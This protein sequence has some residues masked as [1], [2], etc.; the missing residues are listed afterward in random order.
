MSVGVHAKV[1]RAVIG[2]N[3]KE[4]SGYW[5][6]CFNYPLEYET[7]TYEFRSA[8]PPKI[9]DAPDHYS[10][11]PIFCTIYVPSPSINEYRKWIKK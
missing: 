1:K 11:V 9:I 2:E 10:V 5:T 4:V 7:N 3:V 6:D 8:S